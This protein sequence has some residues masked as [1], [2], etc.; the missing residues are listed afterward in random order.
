[1]SSAGVGGT[2]ERHIFNEQHPMTITSWLAGIPRRLVTRS[3][4]RTDYLLSP[5]QLS[6]VALCERCRVDRNGSRLSILRSTAPLR[7]TGSKT[8]KALSESLQ[9]RLRITDSAGLASDGRLVVL[10]PDTQFDGAVAV[11]SHLRTMLGRFVEQPDFEI[12]VYPD[13]EGGSRTTV[14]GDAPS[15]GES[16]VQQPAEMLFARHCPAWKRAIDVA[17]AATGLLLAAPVIA[18]AALAIRVSSPGEVFFAQE[19]EGL[20]GQRFKIYKLRTMRADAESQKSALRVLSEQDG[21]AFKMTN[22]PRVTPVGR[23]LRK[24]SIDELPQ[25]WN[26]LK[27]DMSLVGPRPLPVDESQGCLRWQRQRLTVRPG[28]TCIWQIRGRNIVAFDE[29]VRMDLRYIRRRCLWY[30]LFLIAS[31]P[32]AVVKSKGPR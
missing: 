29:W 11:A 5:G 13:N 12:G 10:L 30:D 19:R 15:S 27:G 7:S 31:T 22:D 24:T 4:V 17:G 32:P 3:R 6:H 28:M 16:V 25:L 14:L 20:G 2:N 18:A 23:L 1:L 9:L 21:P 8:L 26:V